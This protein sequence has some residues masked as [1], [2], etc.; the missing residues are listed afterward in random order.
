[1]VLSPQQLR[2]CGWLLFIGALL[3]ILIL[4][5]EFTVSTSLALTASVSL[6]GGLLVLIGLPGTYIKQR[7][8]IGMLGIIGFFVLWIA[9]LATVLG[10]NIEEIVVA[11]TVAHPTAQSVPPVI[12]NILNLTDLLML[13]GA[14]LYGV[15]TIRAHI[16]PSSI[17]WLL[18]ATVGVM[19]VALFIGGAL[20]SLLYIVGQLLLQS[21]FA[22]LGYSQARWQD[23]DIE[24]EAVEAEEIITTS[25]E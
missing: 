9:L 6:L 13:I 5:I 3:S 19:T 25:Q 20:S 15:Q 8:S 10:V 17:G 23:D 18:I 4:L 1:M 12:V 16:F 21:G 24:P 7:D 11:I 22:R 14:L 2:W